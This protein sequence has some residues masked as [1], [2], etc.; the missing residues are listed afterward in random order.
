M[1]LYARQDP[2]LQHL[3]G[4]A[5]R[6]VRDGAD[7]CIGNLTTRMLLLEMGPW[8][9]PVSVND[10]AGRADNCYVVSPLTA[11]TGYARDELERLQRPL[12][13]VLLRPLI[14]AVAGL[15][16]G[17]RI[18]RIVQVNNWLLSTNLY[19]SDW[20]GEHLAELTTL[21][22][23]RFPDHA[24]AFRSLNP[25]S[26]G[27]LIDALL[28]LG[29]VAIP[30]RQVYLF[31]GRAGENSAWLRHRNCRHDARLLRHSPYRVE[32]GNALT[33]ADFQRLEQ[34]YNQL[35]LE[36]Y[37][38]L[39]PHYRAAW[40]QQGVAAGW[41]ELRVL[42]NDGGRID[43]VA[44]WFAS[45][46]LLSA[47]IVGYDTALPQRTGL[48]RQLTRLCLQETAARR[49]VLNFSSGAARFKRLRGGQ[50]QIEYSLVQIAHLP[51]RRR[52][53]WY[54]LG[55]LLRRIGVPLMK[56]LKL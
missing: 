29:Y 27:A 36:K 22:R 12:L 43:G 23:Q 17:A 55:F 48:Y 53:V 28:G 4:A 20:H 5:A 30:S 2:Q 8:Q 40:L 16:A 51:L 37:S 3:S 26:N 10:G 49:V 14:N 25:A 1:K 15:L 13:T 52:L 7:L 38:R 54:L 46:T 42:R 32:D 11:Y 24:L 9:L 44:G 56:R 19:P 45:D 6:Y 50:A 34:L 18:D 35:Y 41:L 47:P 39:N 31:D 33:D 21:L